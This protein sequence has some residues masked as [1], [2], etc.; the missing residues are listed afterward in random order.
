MSGEVQSDGGRRRTTPVLRPRLISAALVGLTTA[1]VELEP[2]TVGSLWALRLSNCNVC[3]CGKTWSPPSW[4]SKCCA[5][6]FSSSA[7]EHGLVP[8]QMTYESKSSVCQTTN[9]PWRVQ[10][11]QSNTRR[12]AGSGVGNGRSSKR[13]RY[14]PTSPHGLGIGNESREKKGNFE[15][16]A[17][18]TS[19]CTRQ[20]RRCRCSVS[21]LKF[22]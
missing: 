16:P 12:K 20:R 4:G 10:R 17:S 5:S 6:G 13:W 19:M 14:H 2:S 9:P 18:R 8:A 22:E 7:S 15:G 1:A 3:A 11:N 21:R